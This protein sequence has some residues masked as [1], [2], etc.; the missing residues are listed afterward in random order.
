MRI[1]KWFCFLIDCWKELL[2][3]QQLKM[4]IKHTNGERAGHNF[5][6]MKLFKKE[7]QIVFKVLGRIG[8][9]RKG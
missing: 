1:N 7:Q 5:P 6:F 2:P 4:R 3:Y 9:L 8:N